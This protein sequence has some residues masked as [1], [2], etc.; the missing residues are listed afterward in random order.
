MIRILTIS[1]LILF[2]FA[3]Q[4]QNDNAVKYPNDF[5]RIG[6]GARAHGMGLVQVASVSDVTSTYWNPAGLAANPAPFQLGAMHAEW[7][8][9]IAAFD[10]LAFSKSLN[11]EKSSAL[12]IS[13]IRFG[14]DQIPN[15]LRLYEPDGTINYDNVTSFSAADYAIVGSFAR[16]INIKDRPLRVGANAKVIRRV[17]GTF[18]NSWG[19][20]LDI[21]AQYEIK[22]WRFGFVGRDITTTFNA[23][24]FNFTEADKEILDLTNNEI[25]ESNVEIV[26]PTF[27]LGMAYAAQLGE[28]VELLSGLDFDITTDGQRNTLV[29]SKAISIDPKVGLELGYKKFLYLRGGVNNIQ[30]A[31]DDVDGSTQITTIQPNFG[32]GLRFGRLKIDYALTDI[33][34]GSQVLYSNIFS[35]TLDFKQKLKTL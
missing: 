32:I 14:V 10:Y 4:G 19:F 34:D 15:T 23:W 26:R 5:L 9:G 20:G 2:S 28:N 3:A 13:L 29:S 33:G 25:P 30:K 21:G 18:G 7:F 6:V 11:E 8:A 12:G 17:V 24:S 35:L 22:N 31:L 1:C 27:S 16:V